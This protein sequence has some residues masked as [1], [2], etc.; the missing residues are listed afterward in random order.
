L[1]LKARLMVWSRMSRKDIAMAAGLGAQLI[2]ISVPA[3]DQHLRS[4]LR[5]DRSWLMRELVE[6][7]KYARDLG[8]E[9]SV[10]AEDASRGAPDL[11]AQLAEVAQAAGACRIRFAD[12]LGVLDPFLTHERISALR[13]CTDLEV[14][15]HAHDDLGMATAN[16]VCHNGGK[17]WK[18]AIEALLAES[19]FGVNGKVYMGAD[20]WHLRSLCF[21]DKP[22]FLIG[23]SY[24]KYI[25]RD[26]LHKGKEFEV[27]LIRIGFPLHD[28]HHLHRQTTMGY[29]GAM[30]VVTTLVNAVLEKLDSDTMGMGTT[31]YNF[32]LVR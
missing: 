3:S 15:M 23:N 7:I 32:D 11:L 20:L 19:P 30:Q 8:F 21:T 1:G 28:R 26:T 18:K 4:K 29:E 2:D 22:D 24:G 5:R 27:P 10:G 16:I 13:R 31:D 17:R 6:H 9:V 25:Q 12:T 14:E